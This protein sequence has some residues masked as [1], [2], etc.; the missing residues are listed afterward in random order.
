[1]NGL[2]KAPRV[3][4]YLTNRL[5]RAFDGCLVL[6]EPSGRWVACFRGG[7]EAIL[8]DPATPGERMELGFVRAK[9]AVE[10]LVANAS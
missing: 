4:D 6:Q 1:M 5:A 2:P 10:R 3:D 7:D 9:A 8:F